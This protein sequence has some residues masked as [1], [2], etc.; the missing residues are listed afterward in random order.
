[1]RPLTSALQDRYRLRQELGPG[2]MATV[3]RAHDQRIT[4]HDTLRYA[5]VPSRTKGIRAMALIDPPFK[6][7]E[8]KMRRGFR[9]HPVVTI[10]FYGPTNEFASKVAVSVVR[11]PD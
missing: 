7:I 11:A 6:R 3:C 9:G 5:L 2:G 4:G 8:K 10:A 1:M